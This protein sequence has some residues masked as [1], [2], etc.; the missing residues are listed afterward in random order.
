MVMSKV[1]QE[2]YQLRSLLMAQDF[3]AAEALLQE[4]PE[5]LDARNGIGETVLHY[6][7]VED[8]LPGIA[9]LHKRG[10]SLNV[11]NEFGTPVL[12]EVAQLGYRELFSWLAAHGADLKQRA[13]NGQS[14]KDYLFYTRHPEMLGF[15]CGL[16]PDAFSEPESFDDQK[17]HRAHTIQMLQL[18]ASEV[19]QLA[20][21]KNVPHVDI[22]SELL[23]LWFDHTYLSERQTYSDSFSSAENEALAAFHKFFGENHKSLPESQGTIRSWHASQSW[24][25]IMGKAKETLDILEDVSGVQDQKALI[26]TKLELMAQMMDLCVNGPE[27]PW[28]DLPDEMLSHFFVDCYQPDDV[29][30]RAWFTEAELAALAEYAREQRNLWRVVQ[31]SVVTSGPHL[32]P[33]AWGE[34]IHLTRTMAAVLEDRDRS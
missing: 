2:W 17:P 14:L 7:A 8:A 12:F 11:V 28:V 6:L 3:A 5:L 16:Y 4:N 19:E 29:G 27:E 31:E 24:R 1:R 21:E 13:T 30:F 26:L 9:W 22:T 15:I 10:A 33:A 20:Y 34:I 25:G 32:V 18:L 23:C